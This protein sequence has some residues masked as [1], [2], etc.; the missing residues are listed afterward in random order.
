MTEQDTHYANTMLDRLKAGEAWFTP[1]DMIE[2]RKVL[3]EA[4]KRRRAESLRRA[5]ILEQWAQGLDE[6][7]P[8]NSEN[9]KP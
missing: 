6:S 7:A 9:A 4:V 1:E 5:V 2:V 3:A 8:P